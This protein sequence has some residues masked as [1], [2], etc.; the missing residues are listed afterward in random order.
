M[1]LQQLIELLKIEP[2]DRWKT[3][4]F[5]EFRLSFYIDEDSDWL[6]FISKKDKDKGSYDENIEN[7]KGFYEIKGN[8]K[9]N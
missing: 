9:I 7:L 4:Y 5:D 8:E 1:T 6:F 2:Q 3:Y